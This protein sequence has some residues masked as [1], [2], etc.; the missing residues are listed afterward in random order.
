MTELEL[1]EKLRIAGVPFENWGTGKAKTV[2]HLLEEV[3]AGETVLEE[4]DGTLLRQ[5]DVAM[6]DVFY[7]PEGGD[8]LY[9]REDRQVFNDG[10]ERPRTLD[11]SLGEKRHPDETFEEAAERGVRT[12]LGIPAEDL[13]FTPKGVT[14]R[15][16][17]ESPSYPGLQTLYTFHRSAV[18]LPEELYRPDGYVEVGGDKTTYFTWQSQTWPRNPHCSD[19][20][21]PQGTGR[22]YF[23]K[24]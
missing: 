9:L 14:T 3:N 4:R 12:E 19:R 8:S 1:I 11:S 24:R 15:G 16:P 13:E 23:Y 20:P 2:G 18:T 10:R 17:E 6:V 5:V 22:L 21:A 7:H